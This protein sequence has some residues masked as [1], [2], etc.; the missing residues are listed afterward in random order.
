M[1]PTA[2]ELPA[3]SLPAPRLTPATAAALAADL[4]ALPYTTAAVEELLGPVAA[5]ALDRE[6]AEPARRVVA[7]VL[8]SAPHD[9]GDPGSGAR[10]GLAALVSVWMLGDAADAADVAAALP[11]LGLDGAREA[12]LVVKEGGG[13]VRGIVDLSPYEADEPG[14]MWVASDQT[15]LQRRG[16]LPEDHVL[17]I[18]RASLTLAGAT[19]RRP[20]ARALDVGV[21]CGIQTLH[22]L[23]HAEHVTATDLSERAL[24][25][26]RFNL[27]LNADVLGLDRQRLEDRVRLVTGDMLEPVAGERFDLV[28]S[29]PP[30]VITP[31]TDPDAPVLTYRD[32]GREGDRIVAELIAALP[33]HLTEGGTAQLLANWEI[34]AG[35]AE[36]PA[37]AAEG[38][39]GTGP[40]PW[41]VRPRSWIAPGMQAWI[42]QRDSQD[43]AGY[44]ET[45][46][47][48]SSLE[49]DPHR[50]EAAYRGYLE[51]FAARG[52][53][54]VGFGHV[55]LRRPVDD[56]A[57]GR[58]WTV[59]EE[60]TQPV[61]E[62]L[63]AAWAAA[64]AR[65]DRLA[66]GAPDGAGDPALAALRGL[67]LRVAE[68]VSEERHGR[69]GAEHPEVIL[70]RQGAGF[71]RTARLD[72]ATA[73]VLSASDGE[74]SVGQLVGAVAALLELDDAGRAGLLA[75][76]RELY[77]DGFLVEAAQ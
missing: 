6:H 27:L 58:A 21:G 2:P 65:R 77:E 39:D 67:H 37:G 28:V 44:A 16:P 64:V 43:P 4:A 1:S 56:G 57:Q 48:D 55:W 47:Q 31:R 68:D 73:G 29:N 30:F 76:I 9:D 69:F 51:D 17:G 70:A 60:L 49:L 34:P 54:G 22:L 45:W 33:E 32:G 41:D 36:I 66:A 19:Q 74:L 14:R 26:T 52:V 12:G 75:A 10:R 11:A 59:A 35:E 8:A 13:T 46:L 15:A 53:A 40:T 63:G 38:G 71:R 7:R 18:G 24:E 50:Y 61:D 20:V 5:A 3:P 25:F 72:T 62:A 23:A 42:V